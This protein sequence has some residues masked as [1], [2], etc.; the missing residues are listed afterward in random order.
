MNQSRTHRPRIA[1]RTDIIRA[2]WISSLNAGVAPS[3]DIGRSTSTPSADDRPFFE[4]DVVC[5]QHGTKQSRERP[6]PRAE[7]IQYHGKA[8]VLESRGV[9]A[10][11]LRDSS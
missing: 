1:W 6:L 5:R 10:L 8:D 11:N 4:R 7:V 9:K 3:L 2:A